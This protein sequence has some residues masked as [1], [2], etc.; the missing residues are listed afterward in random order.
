[1]FELMKLGRLAGVTEEVLENKE[2]FKTIVERVL[3]PAAVFSE[4]ITEGD[5]GER[6]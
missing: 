6:L 1:M 5:S 4:D 3:L 2:T